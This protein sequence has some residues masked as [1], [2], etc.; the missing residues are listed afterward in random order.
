M[1][2]MRWEPFSELRRMREEMDRLFE[3]FWR[4]PLL[5]MPREEVISPAID[6]FERDNNIVIKAELPGLKRE[7]VEVTATEDSISLKGE[8]KRE[9]EVKEEGYYRRERRAGRFYRSIP[10]PVAIK[11]EEVKAMF[12]NGVLEVVAPKAEEAKEKEKKVPVEG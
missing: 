10:M 9:E 11:P 3:E 2:L 7:D 5:V 1:S 6:M 4:T 12:K 8:F